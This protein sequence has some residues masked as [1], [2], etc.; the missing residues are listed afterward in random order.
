MK[1]E[2]VLT[3]QNRRIDFACK[4]KFKVSVFKN[5]ILVVMMLLSPAALHAAEHHSSNYYSNYVGGNSYQKNSAQFLN[6]IDENF[7]S[8][9][10]D[11]KKLDVQKM[12]KMQACLLYTSPSPRDS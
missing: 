12:R 9:E 5:N 8:Y 11:E 4:F 3:L 6:F 2:N 10:G 1:I 7:Y